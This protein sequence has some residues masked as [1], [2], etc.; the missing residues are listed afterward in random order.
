MGLVHTL[1]KVSNPRRPELS[2]DMKCLVD[3]G[4]T[5]MCI[6][7]S[8]A[9]FLDLEVAEMKDVELADGSFKQYPYVGPIRVDWAG[10]TSFAGALVMGKEPLLGA[11]PMEDMDVLV[12]PKMQKLIFNPNPYKPFQH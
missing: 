1:V 4:S 6:P 11:I 10:R 2:V 7:E 8:M 3:S 9:I 12:H 5:H